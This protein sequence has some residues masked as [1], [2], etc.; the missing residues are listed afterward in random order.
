MPY[1]RP[2]IDS[3]GYHYPTYN[4]VLAY[5]VDGAKT[6][7]G[8]D[9]Y[10][11]SDSQDYQLISIFAKAAF[12]SYC[13][14]AAAYDAHSPATSVGTGLD[15]I[16][17]VNG[18]AR[19]QATKSFAAVTL[20]GAPGTTVANGVIADASGTL[21]DLP[22]SVVI[23]DGGTASATATC[24]RYG[25]VVA[26]KETLT[27]IM[28][29]QLGWTSVSNEAPA[30]PGSVAETDAQLR[31]RQALS[32]AQPSASM[33]EGLEGALRA[34]SEVTRVKIYENDSSQTDS[35]GVPG[36]SVC[37]VVEGGG[38]A[39][40]AETIFNRKPV[41]CGTHGGTGVSV[42]DAY[43]AENTVRFQ[44]PVNV[45]F[46]VAVTLRP[47]AGYDA[48]ATPAAIAG[49]V[50]AY[51]DSLGIGDGLT[52]SM[53]WW[54]AMNAMPAQA[55]PSFSVVS[56]S[57]CRHGGTPGTADIALAFSEAARGNANY[58]T[59]TEANE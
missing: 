43:G 51:L 15:A 41:G 54:A 2:Y 12:D 17:A 39:A 8:Q 1:F 55:A 33:R 10:L 32:T 58:V 28:T 50:T 25:Q 53:L 18:I 5:I 30:T 35:N 34:L 31:A 26:G 24:R 57:C 19:K 56:V 52:A 27:R 42:I 49:S 45:D 22:A 13:A 11:G 59:V 37:C 3:T 36:H 4:D 44:R 47:L 29:P 16:A 20:T 6:I 14:A 9:I 7:F 38:D 48:S 21:W 23:G 46:D 40:I